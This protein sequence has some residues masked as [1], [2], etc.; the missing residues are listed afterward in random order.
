MSNKL[1]NG[2]E[3]EQSVEINFSSVDSISALIMLDPYGRLSLRAFD[4]AKA[5]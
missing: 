5:D 3:A 1:R 2:H 4:D